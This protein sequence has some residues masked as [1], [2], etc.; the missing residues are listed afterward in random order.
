L[1]FLGKYNKESSGKK[2]KKMIKLKGKE[3]TITVPDEFAA[4]A[5]NVADW[6]PLAWSSTPAPVGDTI[7]VRDTMEYIFKQHYFW[8]FSS[9]RSTI[10]ICRF[11]T[12][13]T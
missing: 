10:I 6:P 11:D 4:T 1:L 2:K 5:E 13:C 3:V 8:T 12:I 7:T 9:K